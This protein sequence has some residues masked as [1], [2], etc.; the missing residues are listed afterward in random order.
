MRFLGHTGATS[1]YWSL[2]LNA[3]LCF[4]KQKIHCLEPVCA[5]AGGVHGYIPSWFPLQHV[6]PPPTPTYPPTHPPLLRVLCEK[7]HAPFPL[8]RDLSHLLLTMFC[9]LVCHLL[10]RPMPSCSEHNSRFGLCY[11]A[12]DGGSG[13][14]QPGSPPEPLPAPPCAWQGRPGTTPD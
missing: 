8:L 13:R 12:G 9:L 5:C 1:G 2:P 6:N 14:R 11:R 10:L 7:N 4:P 3:A